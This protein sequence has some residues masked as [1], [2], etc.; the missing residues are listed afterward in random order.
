MKLQPVHIG[1]ADIGDQAALARRCRAGKKFL[2]AI[3]AFDPEAG[4]FKQRAER[5]AHIG[6]IVHD[7]YACISRHGASP[8]LADIG[9]SEV[10]GRS[11]ACIRL[12][13]DAP[14]MRFDDGLANAEADAHAFV[15]GGDKG[16]K[17]AARYF[18]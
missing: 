17:Q 16:L 9:K 3:E 2:R 10:K 1:H 14:A 4:R 7:E 6:V 18:G 11:T 5:I 12:R 13:P 15:L 8:S